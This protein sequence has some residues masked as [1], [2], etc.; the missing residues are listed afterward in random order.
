MK[1][2]ILITGCGIV[3]ALGNEPSVLLDSLRKFQM[4]VTSL[5]AHD[6]RDF[7]KILPAAPIENLNPSEL[8]GDQNLKPLDRAGLLSIMAVEKALRSAGLRPVDLENEEIDMLLGT[9]FCSAKSITQFD[10]NVLLNGPKYAKPLQFAN[11]V[12]NAAGG[13][14]AIWHNLRGANTTVAA[15]KVSGLRALR[16][17]K[18]Q[19]E[20]WGS[21]TVLVG[22]LEELSFETLKTFS[23]AGVLADEPCHSIP[24]SKAR[25]GFALGEGAGFFLLESRTHAEARKATV[26]ARLASVASSYDTSRGE[27]E[28]QA[29]DRLESSIR[30]ALA[31][32]ALE[33]IEIDLIVTSANGSLFEDRVEAKALS[34]VF[35]K[36]QTPVCAPAEYLGDTL[37]FSG[38]LQT[39][40]AIESMSSGTLPGVTPGLDRE[41][42]SQ[43]LYL[44]EE[45][46][47]GSYSH[48][49]ILS[50]GFDGCSAAAV[51]SRA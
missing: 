14:T 46:I 20:N 29:I 22:G 37:G 33:A 12:L 6:E 1:E 19:M 4:A 32:A 5:D 18:I 40:V 13:Q 11:T 25:S 3:T 24:F 10:R 28:S 42:L 44:P 15:G 38:I 23:L 50:L 36:G 48:S 41:P 30:D 39:A 9:M 47:S 34:R 2:E 7:G 17:A 16:Q 21:S 27:D 35:T 31:K 45:S 43:A 8:L 49:L 51:V 26:L